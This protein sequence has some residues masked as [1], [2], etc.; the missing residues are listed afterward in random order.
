MIMW[1]PI[2]KRRE[3]CALQS[4]ARPRQEATTARHRLGETRSLVPSVLV[5]LVALGVAS[6]PLGLAPGCASKSAVSRID[7]EAGASAIVP[8]SPTDP[9]SSDS[10][11]PCKWPRV[12]VE[13]DVYTC[14]LQ[15]TP[16]VRLETC[17]ESCS[18]GRCVSRDCADAE[19]LDAARGCL[20]YGARVDNIDSDAGSPTM[21]LFT[22]NSDFTSSISVEMRIP[23]S[24]PEGYWATFATGLLSGRGA[25]RLSFTMPPAL[26]TAGNTRGGGFRVR[27]DHPALVVQLDS[28][29]LDRMASSSAGTVLRPVQALGLRHLAMTY[30]QLGSN[31]V[32]RTPGSRSG[33]GQVVV[34]AAEDG[35]EVHLTTKANAIVSADET[36]VPASGDAMTFLLDEG[37]AFQLFSAGQGD[38]LTG[39]M[40]E[41][42]HPVAVFSGNVY[43]TYGATVTG[44]NGGDSTL[45]QLPPVE[46]WSDEYVGAWLAPQA[47]CDP[48]G[49]AGS[50]RW[51]VLA[52]DDD[53]NVTVA[54]ASGAILD[55]VPAQFLLGAGES[56]TFLVHGGVAPDGSSVAGDFVL[57]AAAEKRVLL[58]Q[59]LDCEPSL[60]WGIDTRHGA[61]GLSLVLPPGFDH[62]LV[63]VRE[64]HGDVTLDGAV[65]TSGF[66]SA[67]GNGR[68]E[69]RRI[70]SD[71]LGACRDFFDS[72]QVTLGSG[73]IGLSW[74]GMDA[75]CSYAVTVPAHGTPC[76]LPATDCPE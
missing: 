52:A 76:A 10:R 2:M 41:S 39:S 57:T 70:G 75:V 22:S 53:T 55:G 59:W 25:Q 62:Q 36:P 33:A 5:V 4:P 28:A 63:V 58:G 73:A 3:L 24:T 12:C 51:S 20:F 30:P 71:E 66:S 18:L 38:D 29:N 61:D 19:A 1:E 69:V 74:R 11:Q 31:D 6:A 44:F 54:P 15:G 42:N 32:D 34:V 67:G 9:S 27:T 21:L 56:R 60:A 64:A 72:C 48:F 35:T 14:G 13:K 43:S 37:D 65:L 50:G 46:A 8:N 16:G 17:S 45:E 68:F 49:P 23:D 40:L 26:R 7:S 47:N